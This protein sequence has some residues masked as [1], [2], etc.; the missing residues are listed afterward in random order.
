M[1]ITAAEEEKKKENFFPF[2]KQEEKVKS[3]LTGIPPTKRKEKKRERKRGR[4]RAH[5]KEIKILKELFIFQLSH[6][7]YSLFLS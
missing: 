7:K 1:T 4:E 2:L 5:K 3:F 6:C